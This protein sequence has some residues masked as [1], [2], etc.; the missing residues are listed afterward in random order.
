MAGT[1]YYE[2]PDGSVQES[3]TTDA[4]PQPPPGAVLL[5]EDEYNTKRQAIEQ[6]QAQH[7][8]DVQAQETARAKDA[9]DALVAAGFNTGVAQT[10]SGYNPTAPAVALLPSNGA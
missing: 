5:T 8:A 9:Y 3:T 6:A 1:Y 2:L 10:L 4:N 7:Q